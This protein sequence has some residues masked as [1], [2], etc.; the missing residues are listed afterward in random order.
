MERTSDEVLLQTDFGLVDGRQHY[1]AMVA[2]DGR[3]HTTNRD[4]H[5][6]K[7][8]NVGLMWVLWKKVQQAKGANAYSLNSVSDLIFSKK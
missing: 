7:P 1:L 5:S 8:V 6:R 3:I 2:P 4:L